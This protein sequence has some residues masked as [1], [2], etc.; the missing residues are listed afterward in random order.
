[1]AGLDPA[2]IQELLGKSDSRGIYASAVNQFVD[3]GEAGVSV[4]EM[5]PN[6]LTDKDGKAKA[7]ST[8]KQGF[9]NA[10]GSKKVRPDAD[11]IV[12]VIVDGEE[13]YLVRDP[14]YVASSD[15]T[16]AQVEETVQA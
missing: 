3:S 16:S 1:M 11:K 8:L 5:W 6:L 9:E 12:K 14:N 7:V 13:V 15:G 2:K 4:S 10:K